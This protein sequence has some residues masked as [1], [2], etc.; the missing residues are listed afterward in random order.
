MVL[1]DKK[2]LFPPTPGSRP[3]KLRLDRRVLVVVAF[4]VAA[5]GGVWVIRSQVNPG[6]PVIDIRKLEREEDIRRQ[7]IEKGRRC[8]RLMREGKIDE[9]RP[10]LEQV[11]ESDPRFYPAHLMLGYLFLRQGKLPLAE[12]ATRRAYQLEPNDPAIDCQLGQI[13]MMQGKYDSAIELLIRAVRLQKETGEPPEAKYHA[14]LADALTRNGQAAHAV[15]QLNL[16]L[17]ANR[18]ETLALAPMFS[19]QAQLVL[20]KVLVAR[21]ET[22]DAARLFAEAAEQLP[23]EAEA[24]YQAAR[25]YYVQG[26]FAEAASLIEKAVE[27]DPA[28]AEY[29]QLRRQIR[30]GQ[31]GS[32]TSVPVVDLGRANK[33]TDESPEE[34]GLPNP[35]KR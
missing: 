4:I 19:P 6:P 14:T 23:D 31:F 11:T 33:E 12:Q 29:V 34:E 8:E 22:S 25:A 10:L 30:S 35:F 15:D 1:A 5:V 21:G 24:H 32:S 27:L 18:R 20:A 26:K 2:K 16:A 9:A 28:N 7:S 17:D 3:P 13:E